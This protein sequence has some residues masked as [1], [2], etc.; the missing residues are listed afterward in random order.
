MESRSP[1]P[2]IQAIAEKMGFGAGKS[3]CNEQLKAA[4]ALEVGCIC[5][6]ER[7]AH[8]KTSHCH[9]G[10]VW[11]F[12]LQKAGPVHP[13][14]RCEVVSLLGDAAGGG[15]QAKVEEVLVQELLVP[16]SLLCGVR[17]ACLPSFL[18]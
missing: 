3:F 2:L 5:E 18:Y 10:W 4:A 17:P 8:L 6:T 11:F 1:Y 12:L 7:G 13:H 9:V 15:M 16:S 14:P